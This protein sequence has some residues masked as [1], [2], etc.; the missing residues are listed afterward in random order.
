MA[1]CQAGKIDVV[2]ILLRLPDVLAEVNL[3]DALGLTALHHAAAAGY[4]DVTFLLLSNGADR[5][6]RDLH[7]NTPQG[8][9]AKHGVGT[10]MAYMSQQIIA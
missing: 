2:R 3:S 10:L 4:T 6:I 7:G 1:A 5:H 9:A 8:L